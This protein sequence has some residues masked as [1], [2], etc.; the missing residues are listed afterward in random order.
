VKVSLSTLFLVVAVNSFAQE[1]G[2][3]AP[4][5]APT[6]AA[7]QGTLLQGK[8]ESLAE[9]YAETKTDVGLLKRLKFGGYIQARFEDF[10]NSTVASPN[11]RQGFGVRRGRFKAIYIGDWSSFVLQT[12][13]T[14]KGIFLK[15]AEVHLIEPWTKLKLELVAGQQKWPFGYEV[16]QSSGEREFPERTRVVRAFAPGER[17]RGA[18]LNVRIKALRFSGGV[19]DGNGT[20]MKNYLTGT[21]NFTFDNDKEKDIVGRIGFDID[22]L[23]GGISGWAGNT[24]SPETATTP[25]AASPRTRVGA[26]LQVYADLIPVIGATALKGELIRGRTYMSNGTELRGRHAFGWYALLVQNLGLSNAVAVRYDVF[27]GGTGRAPT[28]VTTDPNAVSTLG[29]AVMHYWDDVVRLTAAYDLVKTGLAS[30][31][32]D[33]ED[34]VLTVQLQAKF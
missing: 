17:D 15:D 22:W 12:D 21:G 18:K 23:S 28:A 5:Q 31:G 29:V 11:E 1:A 32:I 10:Q 19:F 7:E 33:P 4:E 3:A 34:N 26:D 20:E 30:G 2:E 27:D 14:P 8:L 25:S 16:V 6:N 24:I 9:Q 13:A